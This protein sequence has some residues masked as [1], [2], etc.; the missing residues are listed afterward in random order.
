MLVSFLLLEP[1][2]ADVNPGVALNVDEIEILQQS[3]VL[4]QEFH[5]LAFCS[6]TLQQIDLSKSP[7]AVPSRGDCDAVIPT[8]QCLTPILN[9]L[10]ADI[11]ICSR[12][13]IAGNT[14]SRSDLTDISRLPSNLWSCEETHST[15]VL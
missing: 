15:N 1:R 9:L 10:R 11:T 13:I 8:M 4:H 2:Y 12:L 3:S 6:E 14:F 7:L 5:A